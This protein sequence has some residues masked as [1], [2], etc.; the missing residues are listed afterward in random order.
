LETLGLLELAVCSSFEV[1]PNPLALKASI[2]S[3]VRNGGQ[4]LVDPLPVHRVQPAFYL[5]GE[6]YLE[7]LDA[8]YGAR[9]GLQHSL[10]LRG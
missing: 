9:D 3:T 7:V 6:S 1:S 5:P 8:L 4:V 10:G 2:A